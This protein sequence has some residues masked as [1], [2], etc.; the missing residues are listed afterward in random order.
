[1][2]ESSR[3]GAGASE[4]GPARERPTIGELFKVFLTAGGISFGGGVVAYLREYLVKVHGWLD[5]DDFLDALEVSET[6]PGLNSVN[7]SVIVGDRMR[8]VIGAAVAVIGLM[9]PGMV[10][11]MTLGVLWDQQR[12]DVNI[13][14]FLVGVAA[15]AVGLL[16]TV[17]LQLGH[18]QFLRPLDLILMAVTFM[19]VSVLKFALGWVLLVVGPIAIWLYRPRGAVET[20]ERFAHL[21]ERFHSHRSHWRH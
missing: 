9:L 20:A 8:G 7:M 6:L 15:S 17:T 16:L 21:R 4:M 19:A 5:D 1:M 14:H 10:V 13:N 2:N 18:K 11:M 3:S 12:H